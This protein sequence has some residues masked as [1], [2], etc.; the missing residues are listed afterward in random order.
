MNKNE[1]N[2]F[3]DLFDKKE[4]EV[5]WAFGVSVSLVLFFLV[6]NFY[7]DFFHYK[8]S[9]S[10]LIICFVGAMLGLLGFALSGIA[11]IVSLFTKEEAANINA[12]NGE[13]T[14]TNILSSYSFL[15]K[16]IAIQCLALF[17]LYFLNEGNA[18]I[19]LIY[20]LNKVIPDIVSILLFYALV[21]VEI[22]HIVFIIL[23]TVALI[24]NCIE[25]YRIKNIYSKMDQVQK[26]IHDEVNEVKIDYI[27]STLIN[28]Y[29]FSQREVIDGLLT[30]IEDSNMQ[31]KESVIKYIKS[32]YDIKSSE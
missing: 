17:L 9:I 2:R 21:G 18:D 24:K 15:A 12:I 28:I 16:N 31:N 6:I 30:F 13:N 20:F 19:A 25:L 7:N 3:Y 10:N 26:S 14:I 22:Y 27:F 4:W 8:E 1:R 11:I 29:E 32:Q 23:Y 5:R